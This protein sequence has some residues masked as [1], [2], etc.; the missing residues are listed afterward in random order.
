MLLM[1][2]RVF[3]SACDYLLLGLLVF[4]LTVTL[5]FCKS[6]LDL[7]SSLVYCTQCIMVAGDELANIYGSSD[8]SRRLWAF[9]II[10]GKKDICF[11]IFG[12]KRAI[13]YLML[14]T[15]E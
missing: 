8:N 11:L 10:N 3:T 13:W 14:L 15:N 2:C 6:H 12:C 4:C 9:Q 5:I 7:T 1:I